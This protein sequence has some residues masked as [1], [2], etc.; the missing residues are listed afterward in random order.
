MHT[1][2]GYPE[3]GGPNEL[4]IPAF[5]R[6]QREEGGEGIEPR[7]RKART[8]RSRRE[9]WAVVD[10]AP[11]SEPMTEEV[12][13]PLD[14]YDFDE[15][16]N[17]CTMAMVINMREDGSITF[18]ST[19]TPAG[20]P[21]TKKSLRG[22]SDKEFDYAQPNQYFVFFMGGKWRVINCQ[23]D[24]LPISDRELTKLWVENLR[25]EEEEGKDNKRLPR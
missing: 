23:Y 17:V 9:I 14:K 19:R 15:A 6:R 8:K 5:R 18:V 4:D 24:A 10:S 2:N 11:A 22:F 7:H 13:H 25:N 21:E 12:K 16:G 1:S 3:T 20:P